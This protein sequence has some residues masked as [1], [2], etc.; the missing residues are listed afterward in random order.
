MF[1]IIST[2]GKQYKVSQDTVLTVNKLE[3]KDGDKITINEVLF[4]CNGDQFSVD[5]VHI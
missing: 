5:F 1:A 2:G 4:A 3:G